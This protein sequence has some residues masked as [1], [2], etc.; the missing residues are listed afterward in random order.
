MTA[1]VQSIRGEVEKLKGEVLNVTVLGKRTFSRRMGK[2]DAGI[3]AR[4]F[5]K[6]DPQ[7][8][9]R[10]TRGKIWT[11]PV[12]VNGHLYLRDQELFYCYDVKG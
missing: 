12:V 9:K 11:H 10:S 5:F 2:M 6:L 8:R 3:Y 1:A 4:A 7:T